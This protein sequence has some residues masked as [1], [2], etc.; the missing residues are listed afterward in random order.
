MVLVQTMSVAIEEAFE[1]KKK[2]MKIMVREGSSAKD[3]EALLKEN[4]R[5][6]FLIE[7]EKSGKRWKVL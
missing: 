4:N 6:N 3:M 2:G 1:K 7:Y 5:L